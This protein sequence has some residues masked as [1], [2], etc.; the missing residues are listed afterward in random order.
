MRV[1]FL[2][3]LLM[4]LDIGAIL[5]ENGTQVLG[6]EAE[7][8]P[9]I[10]RI[11]GNF[12]E[13]RLGRRFFSARGIRYGEPPVGEHRFQPAIPAKPWTTVFDATQEGPSCP[14]PGG[15]LPSEDCLRLN[16]YTPELPSPQK[17]DVKKPVLVFFH[18]GGFYGSSG[19]SSSYGPEYMMDQDIVLV[20][21]N[22]R[23]ATLG[24]ISTGDSHAPGNLGLKDQVEAL[25]WVQKNIESFGGDAKNVT[26]SGYSAGGWSVSL[27]LV[28]PMSKGLFHRA[29]AM[30]GSATTQLK[31]VGEQLHLAKRQAA[32]FDCPTNTT[33]DMMSCLKAQPMEAFTASLENMFDWYYNPILLWAPVV[34]PEIPGVERFLP[35]D[36]EEL[37]RQGKFEQVPLVTG[38]TKDEFGGVTVWW[39]EATRNGNNTYFDQLNNN[40]ERL[41]P[42]LFLYE[43]ETPRSKQISKELREFYFKDQPISVDTVDGLAQLYADGVISFA[44]HRLAKLISER[45]TKPVYYY[46]VT[47]QG[48]YS[49]NV[50]TDTKKPY[51]VVHHDDLLYLFNLKTNFPYFKVDD[52]E[53]QTVKRMTSMWYS[54]AKTGNPIPKNDV[55]F[56][57]VKWDAFTPTNNKYLEI[58]DNLSMKSGLYTERMNKWEQLFPLHPEAGT[59]TKN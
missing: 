38:I 12:M 49:H 41:A 54:F 45:S 48:R 34:E 15:H 44:V 22:Y 2:L 4:A 29:I 47:Y 8:V 25:R 17:P 56:E 5:A 58:G 35:A 39:V 32:L 42:I 43:R 16:V 46:E 3:S 21:V 24:F 57:N 36:P 33:E 23:L 13:S 37:I 6:Q 7:V 59:K 30:S 40:W 9:P 27:H 11:R 31:T 20:V 10:G 26:I 53:Y 51:G 18:P 52:P 14:Q 28:S 50:W 19:Q 1:I 55:A